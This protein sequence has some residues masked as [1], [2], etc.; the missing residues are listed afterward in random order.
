M[1]H[2]SKAVHAAVIKALKTS[3]GVPVYDAIPPTN[4]Q[5]FVS[6]D[7]GAET[8]ADAKDL[9]G[10]ETIIRIH[11]WDSA[12][13]DRGGVLELQRLIYNAMHNARFPIDGLSLTSIDYEFSDSFLDEDGITM[14]GVMH[15]RIRTIG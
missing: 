7:V 11:Q 9:T 12:Q 4:P 8:P 6:V 5:R 10:Q 15:F 3:A 14:H 13:R 2:A 1:A